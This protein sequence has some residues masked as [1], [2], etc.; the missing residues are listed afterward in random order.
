MEDLDYHEPEYLFNGKEGRI[1]FSLP[2]KACESYQY[3]MIRAK[4][5]A[6]ELLQKKYND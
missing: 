3:F 2:R 6:K 5:I 1:A 4:E